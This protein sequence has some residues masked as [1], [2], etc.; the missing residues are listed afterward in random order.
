MSQNQMQH[1]SPV[2]RDF[3]VCAAVPQ[4]KKKF[5]YWAD[6]LPELSENAQMAAPPDNQLVPASQ[7]S[8][9]SAASQG[10]P[11][12][13]RKRGASSSFSTPAQKRIKDNNGGTPR[14]NH[15]TPEDKRRRM[16]EIQRALEAKPGVTPSAAECDASISPTKQPQTAPMT[17]MLGTGKGKQREQSPDSQESNVYEE[18]IFG[19]ASQNSM[20]TPQ[21]T[22]RSAGLRQSASTSSL[23]G[24]ARTPVQELTPEELGDMVQKLSALPDQLRKRR[25]LADKRED[26]ARKRI[27]K[28]EEETVDLSA[29]VELLEAENKRLLE[30]IDQLESGGH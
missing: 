2:D 9:A 11:S 23:R 10:P 24:L 22:R 16:D 3:F 27:E 26:S 8:Q 25:A 5:F 30:L 20:S 29:R 12:T 1:M 17:P 15:N 7:L 28:L 19:P 6:S 13:P 4:C 14:N 21:Q 18:D